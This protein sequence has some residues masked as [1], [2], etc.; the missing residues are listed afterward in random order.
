MNSYFNKRAPPP[1]PPID[2]TP[3][4][5]L[6]DLADILWYE[7]ITRSSAYENFALNCRE[8]LETLDGEFFC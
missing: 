1:E 2:I 3:E 8:I 5:D 6:P 4:N 7:T